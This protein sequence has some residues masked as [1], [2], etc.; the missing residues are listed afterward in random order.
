MRIALAALAIGLIGGAAHGATLPL[1][2][3]DYTRGKCVEGRSDIS[4]SIGLYTLTEGKNRGR[5][6]LSPDGESQ[7]G[8]CLLNRVTASGNRVSGSA[9]C[10]AGNLEIASGTYRFTYDV[11]NSRSF[12]SRGRTYQWCAE[13]R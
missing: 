3:G 9:P 13:H 12:V 4:E 7:D 2:D 5:R 1:E 8:Y 11:I 10:K 6:F